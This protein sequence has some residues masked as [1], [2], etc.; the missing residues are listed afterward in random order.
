MQKVLGGTVLFGVLIYSELKSA[1]CTSM[2]EQVPQIVEH[3]DIL[4]DSN[5]MQEALKYLEHYSE[6]TSA[7]VLWRLARVCYKVY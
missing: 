6:S 7:E 5:R 3:A 2:D 1:K 4:Y